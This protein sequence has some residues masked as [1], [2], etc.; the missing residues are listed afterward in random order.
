[1][2]PCCE[3]TRAAFEVGLSLDQGQG[4][5]SGWSDVVVSSQLRLC[6]TCIIDVMK[7][8]LKRIAIIFLNNK[9]CLCEKGHWDIFISIHWRRVTHICVGKLTIVGSD[10][11]LS[12]AGR[13]AIIRTNGGISLIGPLG[14]NFSD[15]LIGVQTYS[16]KKMYLKIS[17]A[18]WCLFCLGLDVLTILEFATTFGHTG[19]TKLLTPGNLN[20][21]RK[22]CSC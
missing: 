15:I 9:I 17:S 5:Y 7:N 22:V 3:Q 2:G 21:R 1:M 19:N 16:F 8:L 6:H 12:P 13:Q 4:V 10:N 14:T 18:K 20:V 11:G